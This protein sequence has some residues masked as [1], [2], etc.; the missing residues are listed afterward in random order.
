MWSIDLLPDAC[1]SEKAAPRIGRAAIR[2]GRIDVVSSFAPMEI[3]R[4]HRLRATAATSLPGG[5]GGA[6]RRSGN[7]PHHRTPKIKMAS[8]RPL[9]GIKK[10]RII[11]YVKQAVIQSA[12]SAIQIRCAKKV[13]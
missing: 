5:P 11:F 8:K 9:R 1:R 2:I 7:G 3:G 10:N 12:I 6:A 4:D 13:Q